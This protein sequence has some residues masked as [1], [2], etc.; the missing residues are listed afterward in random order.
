MLDTAYRDIA[1]LFANWELHQQQVGE[2]IGRA[3][4]GI[5]IE[6][7]Q[8]RHIGGCKAEWV[9]RWSALQERFRGAP[10]PLHTKSKRFASLKNNP[11]KVAAMLG[12]I[13]DYE[14]LSSNLDRGE[15]WQGAAGEAALWLEDYWRVVGESEQQEAEAEE[16]PALA[17]VVD[18]ILEAPADDEEEGDDETADCALS[19]VDP[20][21]LEEQDETPHDRTAHGAAPRSDGELAAEQ[22]AAAA[23]SLPPRYM[24]LAR[25]AQDEGSW[26]ARVLAS[27]SLPIRLAVYHKLLGAT[28][29]SYPDDWLD[30]AT[31]ELPSLQQLAGLDGISMP[32]LRKR[33]NEA[34]DKLYAANAA[35][36]Q[37]GGTI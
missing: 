35:S 5:P 28:D 19:S 20:D 2:I 6:V 37:R 13:G 32:T 25:A 1:D 34:I 17:D 8:M 15:D 14:E 16:E 7:R 10:G 24:A 31:N 29:D 12:E 3:P 23:L 9:I 30:P 11:D 4:A 21:E 26:T 36:A 22:A 27:E 33:R 18:Q